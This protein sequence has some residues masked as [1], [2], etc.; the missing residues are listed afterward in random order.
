M[1]T[2]A[3]RKRIDEEERERVRAR[4]K[5]GGEHERIVMLIVFL[6]IAGIFLAGHLSGAEIFGDMLKEWWR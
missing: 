1:L 3:D 2:D 4:Q 6:V 5:H